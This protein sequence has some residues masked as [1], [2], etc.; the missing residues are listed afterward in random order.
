MVPFSHQNVEDT[1]DYK[2]V[3]YWYFLRC[4]SYSRNAQITIS[5]SWQR[6]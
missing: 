2:S 4:F 3:Q 6:F 1:E 5:N